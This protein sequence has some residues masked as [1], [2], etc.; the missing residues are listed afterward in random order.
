[1]EVARELDVSP[2]EALLK[3]TGDGISSPMSASSVAGNQRARSVALTSA[4]ASIALFSDGRNM[5][6]E[7]YVVEEETI[8]LAEFLSHQPGDPAP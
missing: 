7:A 3:A 4:S 1:M 8:H 5:K 6:I 2:W